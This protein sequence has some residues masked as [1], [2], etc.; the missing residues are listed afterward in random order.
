MFTLEVLTGEAQQLLQIW[1]DNGVDLRNF[2]VVRQQGYRHIRCLHNV[3]DFDFDTFSK[4]N[5][6]LQNFIRNNNSPFILVSDEL[7]PCTS[8][9]DK[10][11]KHIF[12]N[13]SISDYM[14]FEWPEQIMRYRAALL[15]QITG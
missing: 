12:L 6:P 5:S 7:S 13:G 8:A 15:L 3:L 2:E 11:F 1:R 9:Y 4:I 10:D 14:I